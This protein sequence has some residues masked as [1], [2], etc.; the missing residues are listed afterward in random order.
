MRRALQ[1]FTQGGV[2]VG[3]FDV[4]CHRLHLEHKYAPVG[5]LSPRAVFLRLIACRATVAARQLL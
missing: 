4:K 1:A 2:C 5:A 3:D